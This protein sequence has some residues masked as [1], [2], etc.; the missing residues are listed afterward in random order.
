MASFQSALYTRLSSA[1]AMRGTSS[2]MMRSSSA[3][4]SS[5][6]SVGR[7]GRAAWAQAYWMLRRTVM[8]RMGSSV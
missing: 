2:V 6:T 1:Q 5:S 3:L 4:A 7:E 8:G